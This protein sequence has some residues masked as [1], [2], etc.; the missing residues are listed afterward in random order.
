MARGRVLDRRIHTNEDLAS[1]PVEARYLY[2]AMIIHADDEGRM[3]ASPIFLKAVI[4]PFDDAIRVDTVKR[5]RDQLASI[6]VIK[7]YAAGGKEYLS[8]PNWDKWQPLRKDRNRPSDCPADGNQVATNWQP[9]VNQMTTPT[10]PNLT[11]L[12]PTQPNRNALATK[13]VAHPPA[14]AVHVQFV[15]GFQS[16]YQ[17][18]TGAPFKIDKKH[19][20][21]G[22]SLVKNYGIEECVRKVK[23]LGQL[24]REKSAWFTEDGFAAFTLETLSNRWNNIIPEAVPLSKEEELLAELKKRE[25]S[26]VRGDAI[27][28]NGSKQTANR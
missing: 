11:V 6:G 21:I 26:R 20:V 4:F 27:I 8:H 19:W 9:D 3:K 16:L 28:A 25:E 7:L 13:D 22:A 2:K 5:W 14:K 15:E 24:C 10:Q 18:I 1:C 12:N 17:E 23:L